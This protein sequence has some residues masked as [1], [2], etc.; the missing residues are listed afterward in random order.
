MGIYLAQL[1]ICFATFF[2]NG[3]ITPLILVVG[4]TFI[5]EGIATLPFGLSTTSPH[6]QMA[7]RT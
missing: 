3:D 1:A 6:E 2:R 7:A 4:A 5:L